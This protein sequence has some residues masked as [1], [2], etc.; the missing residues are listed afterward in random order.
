MLKKRRKKHYFIL[1]LL[2]LILITCIAIKI[3]HHHSTVHHQ[4][5][6]EISKIKNNFV[7]KTNTDMRTPIDWKL[8]SETIPYPNLPEYNQIWVDV[9]VKAQR[10]YIMN[11]NHRLYT[12]YCSTGTQSEP[13]PLGRYEIQSQRG[14][15]FYNPKTSMG[16]NYWVSFKDNGVYLFHSVPIDENGNYIETEAEKLGTQTGSHGCIRLSVQDAKWFFENIKTGTPVFI[17]TSQT[18]PSYAKIINTKINFD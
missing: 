12:M 3:S 10:V 1:G 2:I 15:T 17:Q 5:S 9:S 8:S 16:A 14:N 6:V 13:T 4:N 7:K 11:G 18:I